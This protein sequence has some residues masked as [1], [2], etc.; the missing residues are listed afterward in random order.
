MSSLSSS[1]FRA[2]LGAFG[3]VVRENVDLAPFMHLRI[4]GPA[5]L[6]VEP[7]NEHDVARL[8][9]TCLDLGYPLRILGGGSNLLVSDA[10]VEAVVMT[11]SAFNRT[12]RDGATVTTGAGVSLPSLMR[13]TKDAGLA[14]LETLT[15][16]PAVVGGA[17]AMNAGTRDGETFDH[18]VSLLVI[19]PVGEVEVWGKARLQ[20]RYRDGGLAGAIALHATFELRPD[21]PKAIFARLEASLRKRNATQPVTEKSVGCVFQ[22]PPGAAAAKLIDDAGCKLMRVGQISVSAKHAN[23][24]VNEGGG[25]CNDFLRLIEQVQLRVREHAGVELAPEVKTWA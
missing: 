10:G 23:Y 6:F 21:D 8:V 17:V 14:G 18:L 15:G 20:P 25:T 9:R 24:F 5:R 12:V 4:G 13:Q 2:A 22:N 7:A 3:G 11:L 19:N 1:S 16:I